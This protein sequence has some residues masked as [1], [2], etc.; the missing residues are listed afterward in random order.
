MSRRI[1]DDAIL[2]I[3]LFVRKIILAPNRWLTAKTNVDAHFEFLAV[4]GS[5]QLIGQAARQVG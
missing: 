1:L 5:V 2:D 4:A 3:Q